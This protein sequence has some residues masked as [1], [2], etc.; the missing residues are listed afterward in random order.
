MTVT[1]NGKEEQI[2]LE[3]SILEFLTSKEIDPNAVVVEHN[4]NIIEKE[5]LG[6]VM[7]Q[8]NDTLEVLKFVGGG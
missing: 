4:F 5:N 7:L 2:V 3:I 6:S 1:V 8:E